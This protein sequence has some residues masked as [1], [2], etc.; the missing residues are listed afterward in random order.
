MV[1]GYNSHENIVLKKF[2]FVKNTYFVNY[3]DMIKDSKQIISESNNNKFTKEQIK[4][5]FVRSIP[6]NITYKKRLEHELNLIIEKNLF[7]SML[8]ALDI[9]EITKNIPH[10]NKG[11]CGSSLVCYLLG[12]SHIDPIKYKISFARFINK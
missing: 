3:L 10:V 7:G 8:K 9:L 12:M 11:S 4:T 1:K 5:Y 2:I 6:D